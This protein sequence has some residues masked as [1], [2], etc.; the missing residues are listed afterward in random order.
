MD[1]LRNE[2]VE[3]CIDAGLSRPRDEWKDGRADG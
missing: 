2:Y 3:G 1:V